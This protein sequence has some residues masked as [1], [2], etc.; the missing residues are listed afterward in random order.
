M[1]VGAEVLD[2]LQY[3]FNLQVG[4]VQ[5]EILENALLPQLLSN[6][7]HILKRRADQRAKVLSLLKLAQRQPQILGEQVAAYCL[8]V[9][10]NF[11]GFKTDVAQH[12]DIRLHAPAEKAPVALAGLHRQRKSRQMPGT[13][14]NI[15][16]I[17]VFL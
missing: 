6:G 13:L 1:I 7:V 9:I 17:Q 2:H 10:I 11:F 14:V 15:D 12:A 4:V 16:T 5:E 8:H 3:L